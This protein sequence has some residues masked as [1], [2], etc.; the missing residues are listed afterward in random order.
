MIAID[1]DYFGYGAGLV[2]VCFVLGL[3]INTILATL[4]TIRENL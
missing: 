3:I 1:W 2:I 4:K